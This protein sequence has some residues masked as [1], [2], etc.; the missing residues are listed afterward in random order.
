MLNVKRQELKFWFPSSKKDFIKQLLGSLMLIDTNNVSQD[1][2][3]ISSLYF[4]SLEDK[5]L[6]QKLDGILYREKYRLRIYNRDISSGKFEIKRK[7]NSVIEKLSITV[8]NTQIQDILKGDY[9]SIEKNNSL[10]YAAKLMN[11]FHYSPKTIVTYQRYAFYL[12]FNRIRIT[13]DS[14]LSSHGFNADL[15]NIEKIEKNNLTKDNHS[16]LEVKFEDELPD[17]IMKVLYDMPF[18]R[19]AISKYS[20][21]RIDNNTELK[22]DEPYIPF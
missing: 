1:G 22:S 3:E 6:N 11:I 2:Y 13:I 4:D 19:S 17:Y 12:P 14:N 16:I 7:L 20:L 8:T 9:S 15:L 21:S 5:D 18:T 10:A